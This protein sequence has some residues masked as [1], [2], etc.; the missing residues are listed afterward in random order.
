LAEREGWK[1]INVP[2]QGAKDGVKYYKVPDYVVNLIQEREEISK[3][4]R[5]LVSRNEFPDEVSLTENISHETPPG[6]VFVPKYEVTAS[7]GHGLVVHSE[8][9]V[10]YLAFREDWLRNT[11]RLNPKDLFLI[12]TIGDSMYPTLHSGDVLLIEQSTVLRRED[13]LYVFSHE[14]QLR[15]KRIQFRFNGSLAIISDNVQYREEVIP[16][17]QV[18]SIILL[19]RVVWYGRSM[20]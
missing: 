10:D 7:M 3:F 20:I 15:V 8:M 9:I 11:M 4:G 16:L 6:F 2:G 12:N 17:E 1:F 19:G 14:G 18:E 5:P 13:N